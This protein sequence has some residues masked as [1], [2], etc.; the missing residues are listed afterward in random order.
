MVIRAASSCP[1]RSSS[2]SDEGVEL[3]E[4]IDAFAGGRGIRDAQGAWGVLSRN[5]ITRQDA[6]RTSVINAFAPF[7][8]AG[9]FRNGA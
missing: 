3:A 5:L 4:A 2:A 8:N 9:V 1:S 7:F 6:F